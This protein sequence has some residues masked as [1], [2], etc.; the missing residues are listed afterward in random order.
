MMDK[1]VQS[2]LRRIQSSI[3]FSRTTLSLGHTKA[4]QSLGCTKAKHNN[5][6]D[7]R[8]EECVDEN[9]CINQIMKCKDE[10]AMMDD[11]TNT[12]GLLYKG[13]GRMHKD[14]RTNA[15]GRM[16]KDARTGTKTEVRDNGGRGRMQEESR[17]RTNRSGQGRT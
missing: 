1:R 3:L 10:C 2:A 14:R 16:H 13:R 11:G 4:K 12:E 8:H 9:E 5:Q 15:Q 6:I 17:V 7:V